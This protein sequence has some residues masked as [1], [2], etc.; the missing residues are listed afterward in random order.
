MPST[1]VSELCQ[2]GK[3]KEQWENALKDDDFTQILKSLATSLLALI[4]PAF[5]AP[6]VAVLV[7]LWLLRK[8]LNNWC[9]HPVDELLKAS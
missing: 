4:N 7:A 2:N 6:T 9:S 1:L 5:A 3:L 8:G